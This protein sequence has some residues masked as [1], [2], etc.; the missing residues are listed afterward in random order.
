[1]RVS[2][3]DPSL[4][5]AYPVL[6]LIVENDSNPLFAAADK[7][8]AAIVLLKLIPE[9]V[10]VHRK[11]KGVYLLWHIGFTQAA[12]AP[13]KIFDSRIEVQHIHTSRRLDTWAAR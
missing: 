2:K 4:V 7:G 3:D 13:K 6:F 8:L 10:R 5:S 11:K 12:Q 9:V 1:M